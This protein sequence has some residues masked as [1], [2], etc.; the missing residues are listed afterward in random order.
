MVGR[1]VSDWLE[2]DPYYRWVALSPLQL[3][4]CRPTRTIVIR[5]LRDGKPHHA[6]LIVTDLLSPIPTVCQQYSLRAGAEV[7]IR[8][9]KQGLLLTH[10]RKRSWQAQMM[11]ILLNDLAHNLITTFRCQALQNT[12]LAAFGAYR[13]IQEVFN[14]PGRAV[15]QQGRLIELQLLETHPHAK[16]LADALPRFWNICC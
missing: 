4:F 12:P 10:R 13:M 7:D 15:I 6:L 3:A 11:L 16:T 5:W 2:L 14:I 8:N 9:D 1:Q